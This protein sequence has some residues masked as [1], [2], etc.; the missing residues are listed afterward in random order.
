MALYGAFSSSM[1]GM[2][3]QAKSLHN[4]STNIANVNTG[5]YKGTETQFS[6]LLSRSL[7][8]VSDNGGVRPKDIS[9]ITK[10]GLV[11]ASTSSTDV[12]IS[13]QGFFVMN[14]QQDGT[15]ESVYGRDGSF[16]LKTVNPITITGTGG[17][18]VTTK[19]GYIADKNG[20]F[21]Q[22]WAYTNGTVTT[23]GTTSSLRVDQY[24][25]LNNFQATSNASL[26]LNL[27]ASDAIGTNHQYDITVYDTVGKA[28]SVKLN[29][30]KT[31]ISQWNNSVTTSRTPI[32]Q[33]DSV[34]LG[35]TVGEAGDVYS[36][37]VNGNAVSYTTLASDTSLDIIRD[38]LIAIVANDQQLSAKVTA[39][40]GGA[41]TINLTAV[42]AGNALTTTASGV[43]GGITADNSATVGNV[44]ANLTNTTTTATAVAQV[45]TVSLGGAVG[46]AGDIYSTT[47]NGTT[48]SYTTTGTEAS[49]GVIRDNLRA[50][51]QANPSIN[52][53]VTVGT[54][55]VS[56]LTFTAAVPGVAFTS[57]STATQAPASTT[58]TTT[59]N[60]PGPILT[61][62]ND[63][64]LA[65]P[66]T[67][68][69]A[70]TFGVGA[71]SSA[72]I[73]ISKMTQ[74]AGE[75]VPGSFTKDGFASASMKSF[76][77]DSAGN[78]IGTFDDNTVRPIYQ[79]ALGVFS[80]PNALQ[81]VN[82]NVFK[83]TNDSGA[84]TVTTAGAEGYASFIPNSRE[85]SNVDIA[86]EFSKMM[87]TQT[88]Y[89]ASST[90]FKTADEMVMVARDLKR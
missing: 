55:G 58:T 20:N 44:T 22:G 69:L 4:I 50:L 86:D 7:Q 49:L 33:V 9:T 19:D 38:K 17:Q 8:N 39:S 29:F 25:F 59:A 11:V 84:V 74:F 28:Q 13:G 62:N 85:L 41:G 30:T 21:V 46:A 79:L 82:G 90:V 71:T 80:N 56:D 83:P 26:D 36:I 1:Q 63:G 54:S 48:V 31:G 64:S 73:D 16:E 42:S 68:T 34:T 47:I 65:S 60:V 2:M 78:I 12:A 75:F 88:A 40:I 15:G 51:I 27:P 70:A 32:A 89:N 3:S 24:A 18:T 14:T 61:F 10:Q 35:G 66:T 6:T 53:V 23:T 45:D 37:T 43:N 52:G 87:M 81:S 77:F 72:V 57:S 5:G 67:L 76:G